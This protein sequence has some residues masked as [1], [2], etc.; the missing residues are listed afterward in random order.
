MQNYWQNAKIF[1]WISNQKLCENQSP[2]K[3]RFSVPLQKAWKSWVWP[4]VRGGFPKVISH[5]ELFD[6]IDFLGVWFYVL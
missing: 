3:A 5:P 6:S 1:T 2:V 4:I